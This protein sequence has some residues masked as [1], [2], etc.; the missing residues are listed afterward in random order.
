LSGARNEALKIA[1]GKYLAFQDS[2]D[3]SCLDRLTKQFNFL[4]SRPD[5]FLVGSRVRVFGAGSSKIIGKIGSNNYLKSLLFFLNPF[6]TSS[7]MVRNFNLNK[8][9]DDLILFDL[10]CTPAEDYD[11][12]LT[13]FESGKFHNLSEPLALYR[14]HDQ[15]TYHSNALRI[16]PIIGSR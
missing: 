16:S 14:M 1:R 7:V 3:L 11:L 2:D 4:E 12:W 15:Q 8:N 9:S 13:L 10:N 6:T 5:Y